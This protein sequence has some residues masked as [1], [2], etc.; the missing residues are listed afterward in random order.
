MKTTIL[1]AALL[2]AGASFASAAT[3]VDP[4]GADLTPKQ[5]AGE[6]GDATVKPLVQLADSAR[7]L[8]D[9]SAAG[10]GFMPVS[11]K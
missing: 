2:I 3:T 1:S 11:K 9:D 8:V 4:A 6:T 10:D 5:V 7:M